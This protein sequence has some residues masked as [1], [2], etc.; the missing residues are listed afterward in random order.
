MSCFLTGYLSFSF[1]PEY[2]FK[3][4]QG[5]LLGVGCFFLLGQ[6]STGWPDSQGWLNSLV[7]PVGYIRRRLKTLG[8]YLHNITYLSW[9]DFPQQSRPKKTSNKPTK[10]TSRLNSFTFSVPK[11]DIV[12]KIPLPYSTGAPP[13]PPRQTS[14]FNILYR[15]SKS[16][17]HFCKSLP[18]SDFSLKFFFYRV[19][20][21]KRPVTRAVKKV[22]KL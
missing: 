20:H 13:V 10:L 3:P 19:C 17:F 11:T 2:M 12:F 21:D 15:L 18:F 9:V 8:V 7:L 16:T 5:E 4:S 1:T 14:V 6:P 22:G